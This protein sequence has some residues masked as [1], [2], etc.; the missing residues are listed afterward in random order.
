MQ[1]LLQD[2]TKALEN[3]DRL[4]ID[5]QLNKAL[6]EQQALA[7]D[8][9]LLSTLKRNPSLKKHFFEEVEDVLVFDKVKFQQFIHNKSFLPD[10]YT[11]F[12]NKI[13]LTD[14][15]GDYLSQKGE[16]VLA[17]PHKD[18]VLQGGQDKEDAKREEIFWNKTLAPDDI[19]RLL[20]PK[21]FTNWKKY[22]KDGEHSVEAPS[23]ND[24]LL[25]KG[26]NLLALHSLAEVYRGK[27]KLIYI[28]PPYNTGGDA[29]IF[30]YNNTFN[31]STWITFIKNR[32]EIAKEMLKDDGFISIAIDH[33]ELFYLGAI[34]D[35]VFGRENR[36]AIVTIVHNPKGRNQ[37]KFFSENSDF[38]IVYAKKK[39]LANFNQIA[40]D[41]DVLETFAEEDEIGRFRWEK[42]IRARTVWSRENRPKNWYPIY[43]SKDLKT[44]TEEY[45]E[46]FFELYPITNQ[47]E[48]AWKIIQPSFKELNLE[49]GYFKAEKEDDKIV[50]YHKYREQ[51][52]F[53]NV[54]TQKKY[55]SEFHG[56]NLLK[57]LIGKTKFSYPKSIYT[58]L[59]TIKIMSKPGEIVMDFFGGSATTGHAVIESNKGQETN[60]RFILVEQLQD[61]I[62]VGIKRLRKV[63]DNNNESFIFNELQQANQQWVEEI[64]AAEDAQ[65]LS[66]IWERM[67]EKAFISYKV[68]VQAIDKHAEDFAQ[69]SLEDQQ[70]FLIEVL[71][72]NQLYV[73]YSEMDDEDYGVSEEDKKLTKAF[74]ELKGK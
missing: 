40:I 24:N 59:D 12:K 72:K 46:D 36:I 43:V 29:N 17:W 7:L 14:N 19:D 22:D 61:H 16:V 15:N 58:V 35:E 67:K 57:K 62:D 25:I 6:I 69:L 47:G 30:T 41:E 13:G 3:D 11:A 70:R 28:D 33:A 52:V 42:L 23:L 71:D 66:K 68:D 53:K 65:T 39:E 64:K 49:E 73:N 48:F 31:H 9:D 21:V 27:V 44:I 45:K 34:A 51:Q 32:L 60:R 1:N 56:T 38:M 55:Q 20:A 10:S 54:W 50:L 4:V 18:C 2:L 37:A 63:L 8:K 74:Y 26:N 5:G